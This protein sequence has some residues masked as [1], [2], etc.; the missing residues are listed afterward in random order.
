MNVS[1][2]K[3]WITTSV[4]KLNHFVRSRYHYSYKIGYIPKME[5]QRVF[6]QMTSREDFILT[7]RNG[8]WFVT[9][10][11]WSPVC[12]QLINE[13][14]KCTV[15]SQVGT[16]VPVG[17]LCPGEAHVLWSGGSEPGSRQTAVRPELSRHPGA[18]GHLHAQALHRG[19]LGVFLSIQL[20]LNGL[21]MARFKSFELWEFECN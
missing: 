8:V 21:M 12:K 11:T 14:V 9:T 2:E 3:V 6:K 7:P 19:Q 20:Y 16:A 13:L 10:D 18:L 4:Q 17:A 1:Y 5:T 15:C